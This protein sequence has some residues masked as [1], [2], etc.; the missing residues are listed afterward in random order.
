M[1]I[2]TDLCLTWDCSDID[3]LMTSWIDD[4]MIIGAAGQTETICH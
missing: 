3:M 1:R 2:P 4:A